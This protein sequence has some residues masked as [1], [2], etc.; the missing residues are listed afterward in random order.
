VGVNFPGARTEARAPIS[1]LENDHAWGW[2]RKQISPPV[3][4]IR[5][6]PPGHGRFRSTDTGS[7]GV[8]RHRWEFREQTSDAG[9]HEPFIAQPDIERFNG[10]CNLA[11]REPAEWLKFAWRQCLLNSHACLLLK[12]LKSEPDP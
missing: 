2:N 10:V 6:R 11:T 8:P 7:H 12:T 5:I 3:R 9:V 1:V 4:A